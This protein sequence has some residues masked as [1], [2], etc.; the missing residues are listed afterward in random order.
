[1]PRLFFR[2]SQRIASNEDF[3]RVLSYKCFVC[4][5]MFRLYAAKNELDMPR[6]GVTVSK[7]CGNA[8]ARNRLKRFGREAFRLHQ[9]E[10][11][12]NFDYI[13]IITQKKPNKRTKNNKISNENTPEYQFKNVE[14]AFLTMVQ[15]LSKKL[16]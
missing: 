8:V 4:K 12:P 14:S 13:L 5:G 1:M 9:H 7:S 3:D 6:F 10:I 16:L 11:H 2:K 15:E